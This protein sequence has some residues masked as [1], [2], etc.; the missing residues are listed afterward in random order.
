[1][2][3]TAQIII[4]ALSIGVYVDVYLELSQAR[5]VVLSAIVSCL[6]A[7]GFGSLLTAFWLWL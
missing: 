7:W 5:G 2:S 6:A 3:L 1:M 4:M